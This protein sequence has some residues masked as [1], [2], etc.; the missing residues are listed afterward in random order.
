[1]KKFEITEEQLK[2]IKSISTAEKEK[3][4]YL[5]EKWYPEAFEKG[6]EIGKWYISK[7]VNK[8]IFYVTNITEDRYYY[9]GFNSGGQW[10]K[11]DYY[12]FNDSGLKHGFRLATEEEVEKALIK[13]AERRGFK[14]GITFISSASETNFK[15]RSYDFIY[16][17]DINCLSAKLGGCIFDNGIW[18]DIVK[19]KYLTKKQAEEEL[20]KIQND[21][22]EYQIID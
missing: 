10:C 5:L 14:K 15:M 13:E 8:H 3:V 16:Q 4:N 18:S 12:S 1:M 19:T 20:T 21:G 11:N 2:E 17:S 6:L 9:Y 22:Y 7:D